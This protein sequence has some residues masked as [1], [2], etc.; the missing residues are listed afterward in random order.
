MFIPR[1]LVQDLIE[2]K[3]DLE[4]RVKR[5]ELILLNESE[6]RIIKLKNY[7]EGGKQ[8]GSE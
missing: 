8:S 5:L 3:R 1:W 4:K 2:S 6:E 7:K